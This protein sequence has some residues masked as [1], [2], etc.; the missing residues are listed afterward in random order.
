[1]YIN[2]KLEHYDSSLNDKENMKNNGYSYIYDYGNLY[3]ELNLNEY[4]R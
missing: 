4:R 3:F 1:M 2:G